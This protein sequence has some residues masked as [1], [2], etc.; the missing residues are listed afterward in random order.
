MPSDKEISTIKPT[1]NLYNYL[2]ECNKNNMN[3]IAI[4][5]PSLKIINNNELD[6]ITYEELFEN[7]DK[8]VSVFKKVMSTCNGVLERLRNS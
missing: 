1:G 3:N 4:S 2:Y 8:C 7:I 6:F 5:V